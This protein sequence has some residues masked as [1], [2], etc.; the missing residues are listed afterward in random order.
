MRKLRNKN[1]NKREPSNKSRNVKIRLRDYQKIGSVVLTWDTKTI[2]T[3]YKKF[4]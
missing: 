2:F 3:N 4:L 1:L